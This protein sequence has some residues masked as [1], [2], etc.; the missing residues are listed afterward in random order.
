MQASITQPELASQIVGTQIFARTRTS[1]RR[2]RGQG[3][4]GDGGGDDGGGPAD[5]LAAAPPEA[6]QAAE[7][8]AMG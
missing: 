4:D 3:G 5:A 6:S 2:L 7:G 1:G 8:E